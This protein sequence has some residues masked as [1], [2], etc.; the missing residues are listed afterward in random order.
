MN[1]LIFINILRTENKNMH[2][3]FML[4]S[5]VL[6]YHQISRYSWWNLKELHIH[7][8]LSHRQTVDGGWRRADYN[9]FD[10]T[11]QMEKEDNNGQPK[12]NANTETTT[13]VMNY[14]KASNDSHSRINNDCQVTTNNDVFI[15]EEEIVNTKNTPL[16]FLRREFRLKN[17]LF[18]SP[19]P[20]LLV[21]NQVSL[22]IFSS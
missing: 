20:N 13:I 10:C 16:T 8:F 17:F 11:M 1:Y 14:T 2:I 12:T 22:Y 15:L 21:S 4:F 5:R 6:F 19:L 9:F 18:N 3:L 7:R